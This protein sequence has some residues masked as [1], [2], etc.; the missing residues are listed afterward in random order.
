MPGV[1]VAGPVNLI[2]QPAT[3]PG[4]TEVGVY[5]LVRAQVFHGLPA[6]AYRSAIFVVGVVEPPLPSFLVLLRPAHCDDGDY[7]L[8]N[9]VLEVWQ[10]VVALTSQ[11]ELGLQ[12]RVTR[13]CIILVSGEMVS[14]ILV[15]W[16]EGDVGVFRRW[17][18][19]SRE[20][21][22]RGTVPCGPR[23]HSPYWFQ[24]FPWVC[25]NPTWHWDRR[26]ACCNLSGLNCHSVFCASPY[27]SPCPECCS[28]AS[29]TWPMLVCPW[30][31]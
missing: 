13:W 11:H 14:L 24:T 16:A 26:W 27:S 7:A 15:G 22:S 4:S 28:L 8:L 18:R 29:G 2:L 5:F 6:H 17:R 21:C 3:F 23:H 25:G 20:L 12:P 19:Q 31:R 9:R 30:R 1:A 10:G